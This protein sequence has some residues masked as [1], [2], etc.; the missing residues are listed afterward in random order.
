[1]AGTRRS[2]VVLGFVLVGCAAKK[3]EPVA[4]APAP[5][6]SVEI[7]ADTPDLSPVPAPAG[8][9]AVGRL[10]RALAVSDAILGWAGLP[11]DLRELFPERTRELDRAI[12]WEAPVEFALVLAQGSPRNPVQAFVSVGL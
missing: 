4:P 1:M 12:A 9:F 3:P 10:T 8:V 6:R 11:V 7:A 2:A 5:P